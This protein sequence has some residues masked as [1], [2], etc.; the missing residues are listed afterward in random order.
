MNSSFFLQNCSKCHQK[1]FSIKYFQFLIFKTFHMINISKTKYQTRCR[2]YFLRKIC[3]CEGLQYKPAFFAFYEGS[4]GVPYWCPH[5]GLNW[6]PHR[7]YFRGPAIVATSEWSLP[8]RV[9]H[10]K[11][12]EGRRRE[13]WA[14]NQNTGKVTYFSQIS[15]KIKCTY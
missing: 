15:R 13:G 8:R 6:G 10:F 12:E 14:R 11:T 4:H 1:Y 5:R 9:W 7:V 3:I 2:N